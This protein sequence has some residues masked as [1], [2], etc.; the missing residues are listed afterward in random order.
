MKL[1]KK[2]VQKI[3]EAIKTAEATTSGEIVPVILSESDDYIYT[4]FLSALIFTI[5]GIYLSEHFNLF[6]YNY[7]ITSMIWSVVGFCI[8]YIS[9][10]KK[11]LLTQNE[12][13]EEVNQRALQAFYAQNLHNTKDQTGILIFISLL[14]KRVIILGDRGINEKV[15][16]NFW[17]EELNHI[18]SSIKNNELPQGLSHVIKDMGEKLS[19]HFPIQADDQNQQAFKVDVSFKKISVHVRTLL[20]QNRA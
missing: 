2:D 12:I 19:T 13:D 15:E 8:P 17:N 5:A 9:G 20:E 11:I 14:E 16:E 4:H 10:I 6:V 3:E 18:L 1:T 7:V